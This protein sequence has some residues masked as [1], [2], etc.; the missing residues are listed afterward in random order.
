M[1]SIFE[2][3]QCCVICKYLSYWSMIGVCMLLNTIFNSISVILWWSVH[4]HM[5]SWGPFYQCSTQDFPSHW[6]LSNIILSD[7]LVK[8]FVCVHWFI[9]KG[10]FTMNKRQCK[11]TKIV[12]KGE[13]AVYQRFLLC[14]QYFQKPFSLGLATV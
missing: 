6:L 9:Q 7:M 11:N 13:K 5:L 10:H 3:Y 1:F 12:R 14:P 8:H 2:S 4:L